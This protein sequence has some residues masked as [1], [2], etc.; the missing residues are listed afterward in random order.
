MRSLILRPN[1]HHR[2]AVRRDV[3]VGVTS[4]TWAQRRLL[5]SPGAGDAPETQG[6]RTPR[7]EQNCMAVRRK[8][9]INLRNV[10]G[11]ELPCRSPASRNYPQMPQA[12]GLVAR[13]GD[14]LAVR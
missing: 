7:I 6:F 8:A 1:E 2:P 13:I 4:R 10:A 12:V 5:Q 14:V 3:T 9:R 11:S